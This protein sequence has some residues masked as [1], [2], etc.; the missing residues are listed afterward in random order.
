MEYGSCLTYFLNQDF[1]SLTYCRSDWV[2]CFYTL[3][4]KACTMRVAAAH[5]CQVLRLPLCSVD[6][7]E[8]A[9][10]GLLRN[11]RGEWRTVRRFRSAVVYPV[12][13]FLCLQARIS[14]FDVFFKAPTLLSLLPQYKPPM[15]LVA[16]PC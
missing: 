5:A 14:R 8:L 2:R 3:C 13:V 10:V 11:E 9:F 16:V 6:S 15:G 7:S 4:S 1:N 12:S